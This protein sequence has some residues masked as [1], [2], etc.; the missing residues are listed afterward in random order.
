MLTRSTPTLL[1]LLRA[2]L[3]RSPMTWRLFSQDR[4]V[5]PRPGPNSTSRSM[6]S[7]PVWRHG[8]V[9]EA[10]HRRS[11]D[12]SIEFVVAYFAALRSG[13]VAVPINPEST[14]TELQAMINDCGARVLFTAKPQPASRAFIR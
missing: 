10:S 2:R 5:A 11:V 13:Y 7:Q 9:A 14:A 8:L 4:Y 6:P 12:N 1:I 3:V